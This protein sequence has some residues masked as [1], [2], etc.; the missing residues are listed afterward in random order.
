MLAIRGQ[1]AL[2]RGLAVNS[3]LLL[4]KELQALIGLV[5]SFR[6]IRGAGILTEVIHGPFD[7][8][9]DIV[10]VKR[11]QALESELRVVLMGQ[12]VG[13]S[14]SQITPMDGV[15]PSHQAQASTPYA[16]IKT[17]CSRKPQPRVSNDKAPTLPV[18][19]DIPIAC[20]PHP[21]E[22]NESKDSNITISG[23]GRGLTATAYVP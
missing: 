9:V 3:Y 17:K 4:F 8:D 11:A 16:Q 2:K 18:P 10:L 21:S 5:M 20:P 15:N 23:F 19:S 13:Q 14:V 22:P 7:V 12:S 6:G 1:E